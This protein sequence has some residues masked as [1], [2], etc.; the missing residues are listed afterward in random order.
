MIKIDIKPISIN[1]AYTGRRFKTDKYKIFKK[2]FKLLVDKKIK[3]PEK[4]FY[5]VFEFGFSNVL[6][7][8]DGSIKNTQ[9]TLQDIL[10]FN[11]VVI[12]GGWTVKKKVDK[13][14]EYIKY[15]FV[16]ENEKE[17]LINKIKE[18]L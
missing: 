4:S 2:K 16:E 6:S 17:L 14:K 15:Y 13:G 18:T 8:W 3:A 9:D 12:L 10:K 1:E 11:D 7:D 5:I